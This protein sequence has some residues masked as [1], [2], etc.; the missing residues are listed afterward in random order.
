MG[1]TMGDACG[2]GPEILLKAHS[3]GELPASVVVIGDFEILRH[4]GELLGY[5]VRLERTDA[6]NRCAPHVLNV[7]DAGILR[8]EDLEIGRVSAPAGAAALRYVEIGT[9]LALDGT[10]RALVTLPM[11]KESTALRFPGFRGH[12]EV[13]AEICGTADYAMMLASDRLIATHVSTH[14][15]L[16]EAVRLVKTE[17]VHRVIRLTG[18]GVRALRD[19]C[20]IGVAGLNPHA[21]E[22]GLLGSEEREEIEPAIER[23]RSDGMEVSGPVSPDIVFQQ[24]ARG[25]FDA[26]VC[27]YHDQGHIPMKLLDFEGGVNVTLGLPI[28]RTSVDHGT[29]FDI[30]YRGV[31][32]TMSL[33]KACAIAE[34]LSGCRGGSGTATGEG[35]RRPCRNT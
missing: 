22:H 27:M 7:L 16:R 29:A 30:A 35:W 13:V 11:N 14:V 23:A 20:R 21:G 15:S 33:V 34:Q 26:V 3:S 25:R 2:V 12:T 8:R 18:E 6:P 4:C 24:A 19:R 32:S 9:R 10:I 5:D 17:R 28:V 1:I 31:A